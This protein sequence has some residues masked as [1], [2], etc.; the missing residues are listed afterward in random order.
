MSQKHLEKLV[1]KA[2]DDDLSSEERV[3][4]DRALADS[5]ELRRFQ[6]DLIN[7]RTLSRAGAPPCNP[8]LAT[9][10]QQEVDKKYANAKV[11]S[12]FLRPQTWALAAAAVI[13]FGFGW[14]QF[15]SKEIDGPNDPLAGTPLP[16]TVPTPVALAQSAY[17]LSIQTMED[18]ARTQLN[19]IDPEL[20]VVFAE[21]WHILNRAIQRCEQ[22]IEA[23]PQA[24]SSYDLLTYVY[25]AKID[26]LE[27]IL[28]T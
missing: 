16:Q 4:L 19:N 24:H 2:M 11:R 23:D 26:L 14:L 9:R 12:I 18:Q 17:H 25:Q 3:L 8:T 10:L 5:E 6:D 22:S 27:L 20:A 15:G 21:N 28:Q 13:L 7:I 1:V